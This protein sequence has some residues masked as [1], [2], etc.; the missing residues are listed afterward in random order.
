MRLCPNGNRLVI[1]RDEAQKKTDGGIII[2]DVAQD[3]PAR[4]Q[5]VA[6]GSDY[7]GVGRTGAVVLIGRYAGVDVEL[8]GEKL[9]IVNGDDVLGEVRK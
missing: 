4:G 1:R 2:P 8:D 9:T 6:V 3:A 7:K 5:V